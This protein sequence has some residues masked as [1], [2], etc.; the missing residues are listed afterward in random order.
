[1][2][3]SNPTNKGNGKLELA[4]PARLEPILRHTL[5]ETQ[6]IEAIFLIV[7]RNLGSL[8]WNNLIPEA[9]LQ[10]LEETVTLLESERLSI[11][12]K[13]KLGDQLTALELEV[14]VEKQRIRDILILFQGLF[15]EQR[16]CA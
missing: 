13:L 8:S 5:D 1:M 6:E 9:Q 11:E 3:S 15:L 4:N 10:M 12:K 7:L 16:T 2:K 14:T